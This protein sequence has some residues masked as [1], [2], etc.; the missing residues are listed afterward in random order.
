[1]RVFLVLHLLVSISQDQPIYRL[2]PQATA[3]SFTRIA[4]YVPG[5]DVTHHSRL[6][7]DQ[8]I[9]LIGFHIVILQMLWLQCFLWKKNF[10]S[11]TWCPSWHNSPLTLKQQSGSTRRFAS[12][13]KISTPQ[14]ICNSGRQLWQDNRD[15][16]G[17]EA[18]EGFPCW[19]CGLT[20]ELRNSKTDQISHDH[21]IWVDYLATG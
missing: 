21:K 10:H 6:D 3:T 15:Q 7:L 12:L 16:T 19:H 11:V 14:P 13:E 20:K 5:S 9:S 2:S 17:S 1:M 8:V 18:G 4:E